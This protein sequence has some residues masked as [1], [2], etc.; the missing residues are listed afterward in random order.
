MDHSFLIQQLWGDYDKALDWG[1]QRIANN[2]KAA[3]EIIKLYDEMMAAGQ[4]DQAEY[5]KVNVNFLDN[6]VGD[7]TTQDQNQE[8]K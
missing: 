4:Q 8:K 7:H 5:G 1:D 6:L 2:I 3:I